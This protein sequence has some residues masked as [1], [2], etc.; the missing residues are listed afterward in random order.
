M[1]FSYKRLL[2]LSLTLLLLSFL[3]HT[4]GCIMGDTGPCKTDT[5]CA[6]YFPIKLYCARNWCVPKAVAE[7][8]KRQDRPKDAGDQ[9]EPTRPEQNP[10]TPCNTCNLGQTRDCYPQKGCDPTQGSCRGTCKK[11]KQSCIQ[12]KQGCTQWSTCKDS[13]APQPEICGDNEDN[14]CNGQ[15]DDGCQACKPGSTEGCYRATTGCQKGQH[16]YQCQGPCKS[17]NRECNQQGKWEEC[18]G[19]IGP[20]P[21]ICTDQ[22]DNNCDNKVDNLC[23][24]I[25]AGQ[26]GQ[27]GLKDHTTIPTQ[28]LFNLPRVLMFLGSKLHIL[29]ANNKIR[30]LDN[31]HGELTTS[32][33]TFS[34]PRGL[35]FD[36]QGS[37]YIADTENHTI[38]VITGISPSKVF[39]GKKGESGG[40]SGSKLEAR[41]NRPHGLAFDAKSNLYVAD[42]DNHAIRKIT[43]GGTVSVF[44]G[45]IGSPGDRDSSNPKE[46]RLNTPT[47]LVHHNGILYIA[48]TNN[49]KIR[50]IDLAKNVFATLAK[51]DSYDRPRGLAIHPDGSLYIADTGHHVIKKYDPKRDNSTVV[52]GTN[53]T[54]GKRDGAITRNANP[55]NNPA[56]QFNGP[57]AIAFDPEGHLYIADTKNHVLRKITY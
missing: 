36:T 19:D 12:T 7:W 53:Q 6:H 39:A 47:A 16:S 22:K 2:L 46:A 40:Q 15:V 33:A 14:D 8:A 18:K 44:A 3:L 34:A 52:A 41:F 10:D 13:V 25:F 20:S 51:G 37:L 5:D 26:V 32:S 11:G 45:K 43:P 35:A 30:V 48:D 57:E 49:S 21:E 9:P 56:A 1:S 55:T 38:Q 42:T 24:N 4:S 54:P 28:G 27:A 23:V 50:T 17:G 29:D 31:A